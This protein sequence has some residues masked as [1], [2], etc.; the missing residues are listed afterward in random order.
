MSENEEEKSEW[1][2]VLV[3]LPEKI[4]PKCSRKYPL[5]EK[6]C[7]ECGT[8]LIEENEL[9][10]YR[11]T[12]EQ[13]KQYEAE[14]QRRSEEERRNQNQKIEYLEEENRRMRQKLEAVEEES[15]RNKSSKKG[16]FA[17]YAI[18]ALLL[19]FGIVSYKMYDKI[20]KLEERASVATATTVRT[21]NNDRPS[22]PNVKINEN[23]N[24]QE[25]VNKTQSEQTDEQT[26]IT[27]P[28][29]QPKIPSVRQQQTQSQQIAAARQSTAQHYN[30]GDI[31]TFGSYPFYADGSEKAIDW[32]ILDID[33]NNNALVI[34]DY[35][36]D[37]V[38]YNKEWVAITWEDSSIRKWLNNKFLNKAFSTEQRRKI[39][40]SRIANKDNAR[41][42]TRG[43]NATND[44]LFLLSIE[45]ANKYFNSDE[46]RI[47]YPTPY[48]KSKKSVNGD[49]Y[50]SSSD[51]STDRGGS[52]WWWLR[53][54][55]D[56]QYAAAFVLSAGFVTAHGRDVGLEDGG[57][58]A[59]LKINL[60]NL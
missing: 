23:V 16:G 4:C 10:K 27:K 9:G 6:Y 1:E 56:L 51:V 17:K 26:K 20:Q 11:K 36:L 38:S 14:Q 50:V 47:A 42:N 41:Y 39:I 33:A 45:E 53:S 40:S 43:G 55:G 52:C 30:V 28:K 13:H 35:A 7:S 48:A 21:D 29:K 18:I 54:P 19:A 3:P 2:D 25:T 32:I 49:L 44:K 34:S 58:R 60:N 15:I 22:N 8:N 5:T 46:S 37:N 31:I 24:I 57:V 12:E 59:A